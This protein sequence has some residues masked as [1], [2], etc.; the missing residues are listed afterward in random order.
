MTGKELTEREKIKTLEEE[1][2][3]TVKSS[4]VGLDLISIFIGMTDNS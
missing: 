3:K 4:D 2:D 1:A